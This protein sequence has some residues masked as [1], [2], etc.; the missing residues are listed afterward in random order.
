VL[1]GKELFLKHLHPDDRKDYFLIHNDL[2]SGTR[3]SEL[4]II[5]R[6]G[7]QKLIMGRARIEYD[8]AGSLSRMYGTMQDFTE[9]K[10][11]ESSLRASESRYRSLFS[12]MQE[13]FALYEITADAQGET[14]DCRL[15]DINPAFEHLTGLKR[16]MVLGRSLAELYPDIEKQWIEIF[17]QVGQTGSA[18]RFE[19]YSADS[20]RYYSIVAYRPQACRVAVIFT[21][22]TRQKQAETLI[23]KNESRLESLHL[24]SKKVF[25]SESELIDF[26]LDEAVRLTESKVGYFHILHDG[27]PASESTAWSSQ[28]RALCR[29]DSLP[30]THCLAHEGIWADCIRRKK[31]VIHARADQGAE[32]GNFPRNHIE[33]L[34]HMC[35]PIFENGRIVAAAGVGNKQAPYEE[36]DVL[37]MQL[38]MDGLWR[39]LARR[40]AEQRLKQSNADLAE[41]AGQRAAELEK[42]N[43]LMRI[44]NLRKEKA[45]A[46]L[47][48]S[49]KRFS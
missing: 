12:S 4:R 43:E 10:Q 35:V 49:E 1:P 26:A 33:I 15:I 34:S 6:D 7:S 45:L 36:T 21:D 32:P 19:S 2:S 17:G 8:A 41:K 25:M 39:E 23:K 28:A 3:V 13:G 48:E 18:K 27:K 9:R 5:A 20:S 46:D 40:R 29:I 42:I 16:E 22:I 14:S 30:Q 24:L 47:A 31:P 44:E 11:M 38:F 37:Q